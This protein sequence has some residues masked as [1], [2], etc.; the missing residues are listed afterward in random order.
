[1]FGGETQLVMTHLI[2]TRRLS[3]NDVKEAEKHLRELLKNKKE[4]KL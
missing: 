3:L 2:E 4:R 1:V